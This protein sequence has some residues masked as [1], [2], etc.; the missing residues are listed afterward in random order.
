MYIHVC[1][2]ACVYSI[3][4]YMRIMYISNI[5]TIFY[6]VCAIHMRRPD[7]RILTTLISSERGAAPLGREEGGR[8]RDALR[9]T[10]VQSVRSRA[11]NI[12]EIILFPHIYPSA[13]LTNA[14]NCST[15][16]LRL[17]LSRSLSSLLSPL[18]LYPLVPQSR[19]TLSLSLSPFVSLSLYTLRPLSLFLH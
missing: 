16:V 11:R 7:L 4:I 3:Y 13:A 5:Y 10:A 12:S 19:F 8:S 9:S 15:V 6:V 1:A 17:S 2:C 18:F 14:W